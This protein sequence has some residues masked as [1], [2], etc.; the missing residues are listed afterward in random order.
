MDI[1]FHLCPDSDEPKLT[2]SVNGR[3]S[4]PKELDAIAQALNY[5]P[6]VS[7]AV[8]GRAGKILLKEAESDARPVTPTKEEPTVFRPDG[9]LGH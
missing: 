6:A 7:K 8:S 5:D 9:T 3:D 4:S 2:V 1:V